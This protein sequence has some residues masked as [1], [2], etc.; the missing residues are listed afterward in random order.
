MTLRRALASAQPSFVRAFR[1]WLHRKRPPRTQDDLHAYWRSPPDSR[2]QPDCYLAVSDDRSEALRLL[3]ERHV[4]DPASCSVLEIGCNAGRNLECLRNSGFGQ[5]AGV[6]ISRSALDSLRRAYPQLAANAE[7]H[8]GPVEQVLPSLDQAYDVVFTMAVLEH[9]HPESEHVF[10]EM[11]R[12]SKTLLVTVEDEKGLSERHYA[13][14]YARVFSQLGMVEQEQLTE[15][16]TVL[17]KGF[18]A[19]VFEHPSAR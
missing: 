6:E 11:V 14:N 10:A 15:F 7:L 2:N 12:V 17:P 5:L 1:I 16:S 8:E 13:R 3:L 18:V 4:S 9:L 19:R